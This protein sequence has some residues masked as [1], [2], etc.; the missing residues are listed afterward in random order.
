MTINLCAIITE[1]DNVQYTE[2]TARSSHQDRENQKN[3]LNSMIENS[4][5]RK[6]ENSCAIKIQRAWRNYQTY[7]MVH[8]IYLRE[9]RLK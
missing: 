5:R 1:E 4:N 9:R 6:N 2:K 3:E 8:Q 7:K